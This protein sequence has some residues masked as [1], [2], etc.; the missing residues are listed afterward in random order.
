MISLPVASFGESNFKLV[1]V[2]NYN[3]DVGVLKLKSGQYLALLLRCTH[4]GQAITK[5]G[6]GYFCPLHGS[7]FSPM[8]DVVKG[9][10]TSPLQHL[11]I[12][13]DNQNL[14]IQLNAAYYS[15]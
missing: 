2:N 11:P 12:K 7:R 8:G 6:T 14:V 9:P 1:R 4:A 10:A 5:T 15:S 3:Y 13:I